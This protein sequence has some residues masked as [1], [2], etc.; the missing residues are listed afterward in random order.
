MKLLSI[1]IP[2]YNVERYIRE[3]LESI[4]RQGLSDDEFEIILVNDGTP[5]NSIGVVS[6]YI[7]SHDN[8]IVLNQNNQGVSIARNAGLTKSQGK[9]VY[10]M[11]PD[12][13][14]VDD[15]LSALLP[16]A[17]ASDAEIL[18]ADY[19]RFDDG[20]DYSNLLHV[21]QVYSEH[22]KTGEQAYLQDLSPYECYIWLM[23]IKRDF[24]INNKITFKPFWYE[25]TLFCQECFVKAKFVLRTRF[26]L[27]VYRLHAGSFTSSMNI[28]KMKDLNSCLSALIE[29]KETGSFSDVV[30]SKL[31]NN[32]FASFSYSLW[33]ITHNDVL[34]KDRRIIISDLK[35]KIPPSHFM[36]YGDIKQMIVSLLFRLCPYFYLS[37][38]KI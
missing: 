21:D 24:L 13:L 17:I 22:K 26:R 34:Y 10:F 2:V 8:V 32:I 12:D 23:L 1:I 20:C 30:K 25:D 6:D 33:C 4:F 5:D 11:D 19:C 7:D 37:L 29:L 3:C 15:A 35:A 28:N 27:Y 9:Y 38:R 36:F 16:K 31:S 18:M 14:L